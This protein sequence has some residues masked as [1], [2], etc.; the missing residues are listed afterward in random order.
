M[1]SIALAPTLAGNP[2]RVRDVALVLGGVVLV[3]A[4]AQVVPL[5]FTPVPI[6]G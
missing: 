3:A 6:T 2:S 1:S 4:A 5:P